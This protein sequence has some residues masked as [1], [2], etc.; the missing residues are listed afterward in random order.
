[1]KI[2]GTGVHRA[3]GREIMRATD[4]SSKEAPRSR[5][6][7][8]PPPG[9]FCTRRKGHEGPCAALEQHR[10]YMPHCDQSVLHAPGACRPCDLYPDWQEMRKRQRINFTGESD[11]LKAP[12]PTTYFREEETI[13]QWPGNR[14]T[15]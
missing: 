11:E 1:M 14:A 15:S 9:W 2:M 10:A 8:L 6:C 4:F 12:C 7:S 3:L 5:G 13:N